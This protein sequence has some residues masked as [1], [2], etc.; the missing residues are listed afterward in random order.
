MTLYTANITHVEAGEPHFEHFAVKNGNIHQ[1]ANNLIE[2]DFVEEIPTDESG[3]YFNGEMFYNVYFDASKVASDNYP[4]HMAHYMP[5][6]GEPAF[7]MSQ[8]VPMVADASFAG[9][10]QYSLH[11]FA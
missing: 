2:N 10:N 6:V 4:C 3:Q 8:D 5:A 11:S 9:E 7:P 1:I